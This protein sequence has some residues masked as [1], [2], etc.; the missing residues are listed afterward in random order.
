MVLGLLKQHGQMPRCD[1]VSAVVAKGYA[2]ASNIYTSLRRLRAAGQ[3]EIRR[4]DGT[5][6]VSL[7]EAN[8]GRRNAIRHVIQGH[9]T[10]RR[11]TAKFTAKVAGCPAYSGPATLSF[12]K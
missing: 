3:I 8:N 7:P 9:A 4:M 5:S 12:I 2:H 6:W 11:G 1:L 10:V